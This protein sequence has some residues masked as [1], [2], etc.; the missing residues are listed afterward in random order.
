[1]R[2]TRE[3]GL[4][5]ALRLGRNA[6]LVAW[7]CV[8]LLPLVWMVSTSLTETGQEFSFPPQF[9]PH[10]ITWQNYPAIFQSGL[11]FHLFFLNT[12]AVVVT[13]T[14]GIV[15]SSSLVGFAFAR[16]RYP[17]R[18]IW[19]MILLSTMMLPGAVT[20]LPTYMIFKWLGWL[21]TLLPLTVPAWFG[22]GA[23][24]IFLFRQFFTTIPRDL[25][26]AARI[27]GASTFRLYSQILLPSCKPVMAAVAIF[28][29][30]GGWND[31]MGPLIYLHSTRNLTLSVGLMLFRNNYFGYWN[32]M[33]GAG[34]LMM[35][36]MLV[37]FFAAQRYFIQGIVTTG[38]SGT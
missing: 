6:I 15:L 23:F 37:L 34:L 28:S 4:K 3:R 24:N 11:P 5:I 17:G 1:M 36:P 8:F 12:A 25:D 18:N 20:L 27:D 30:V 32:K 31:F 26:D 13:S 38:M 29:I 14:I 35:L 21:D 10:P 33:M 7:S 9:I 2:I 22:G 19:F 16:L